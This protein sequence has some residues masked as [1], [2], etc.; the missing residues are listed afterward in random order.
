MAQGDIII[1]VILSIGGLVGSSML[2]V[3]FGILG[4]CICS[5][6]DKITLL[7]DRPNVRSNEML[8]EFAA[9]TLRAAYAC[10]GAFIAG[11]IVAFFLSSAP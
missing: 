10:T 6:A 3:P 4:I 9:A 5:F 1:V 2:L 7:Q 11:R 8:L